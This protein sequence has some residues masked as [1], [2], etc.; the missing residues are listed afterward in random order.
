MDFNVDPMSACIASKAGDELHIWDEITIANG[1]TAEMAAEIIRRY[2]PR[3]I[4]VYP[5]PSGRA[6]R[7]SAPVGETDLAILRHAG[8]HVIAP[9]KAPA[10]VDRINALQA[11]LMNGA[12]RRRLFVHPGCRQTIKSLEGQTYKEGTSQP[13]KDGTDHMADAA[14]Y[15]VWGEFPIQAVKTGSGRTRGLF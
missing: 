4:R 1:N 3:D 12:G 9:R 14:G 10:V 13:M 7:T 8:F 5:D 6:R 2:G 15:L 11:L